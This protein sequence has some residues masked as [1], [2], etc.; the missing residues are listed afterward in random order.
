MRPYTCADCGYYSFDETEFVE[1][2]ESPPALLCWSGG[3]LDNG[4]VACSKRRQR[5]KL[6][7]KI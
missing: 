4:D 7:I 2:P 5:E 3:D 6:I 1:L